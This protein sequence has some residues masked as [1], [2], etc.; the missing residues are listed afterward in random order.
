MKKPA[1]QFYP[2]DWRKDQNLSRASLEAKGALIE[3]MC[4]A[5]ECEKRGVLKTGGVPWSVEEIAHAMGGD[6]DVNIKAIEELLRLKVL[7]KDRKNT[8]FQSRMCKDEKLRKVRQDAGSKGGNPI[9]V[10]QTFKQKPTPSSSTSS[11]TSV[12]NTGGEGS[13][14]CVWNVYEEVR[15][16]QAEYT[17]IVSTSY[18]D[19]VTAENSLLKYH[20]FM[21]S[22]GKYPVTRKQAF[23]GFKLWLMN[24]KT[25]PTPT[26][27][28]PKKMIM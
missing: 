21:E 27:S 24:E 20:L 23:S 8:I 18:K 4:L 12:I 2:G 13:N 9:L 22:K 16:N 15:N 5:F 6:K 3:I 11:S 10:N 25:A 17:R 7:K 19:P 14:L 26:G 28:E 1:F